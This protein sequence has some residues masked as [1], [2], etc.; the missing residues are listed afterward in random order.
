VDNCI[1]PRLIISDTDSSDDW[2]KSQ[3]RHWNHR[4]QIA[5]GHAV[6]SKRYNEVPA[7]P[8]QNTYQ[9]YPANDFDIAFNE[10]PAILDLNSGPRMWLRTWL[11]TNPYR[12]PNRGE[13][14]SLETLS[15]LPK[16]EI[17]SWLGQHISL[18]PYPEAEPIVTIPEETLCQK[19]TPRYRSKCRRSQRR[20][21][22]IPET[23]GENRVLECTH[24]CGQSFDV[25]GQWA[26]HERRNIEEWKCHI[27]K[28]ISPRK[29][30]LR[31]HLRQYHGFRGAVKKS[32]CRQLLQPN[33]RPCGFCLKQFDNWSEWLNHVGAHFQSR[34]PGGP[35][36]MA[37]WNEAVDVNLDLG[38]SDDDDDDDNDDNDD[39]DNDQGY[40]EPDESSP[41]DDNSTT[42][43]NSDS[44]TKRKEAS[45]G[46]GSKKSSRSSGSS[47]SGAAGSRKSKSHKRASGEPLYREHS[48]S[49]NDGDGD[50][51]SKSSDK[52]DKYRA[53]GLPAKKER[54]RHARDKYSTKSRHYHGTHP[55]SKTKPGSDCNRHLEQQHGR[56][57]DKGKGNDET[58]MTSGQTP[59]TPAKQH[60]PSPQRPVS[61]NW[62]LNGVIRDTEMTIIDSRWTRILYF[63]GNGARELS[64]S[65]ILE[66]VMLRFNQLASCDATC[67]DRF[68]LLVG[69]STGDLLA[70]M[71]SKLSCVETHPSQSL[72]LRPSPESNATFMLSQ[73]KHLTSLADT[74]RHI[75]NSPP[76][77]LDPDLV[78]RLDHRAES[79]D[80]SPAPKPELSSWHRDWKPQNIPIQRRA[81]K[82]PSCKLP[83]TKAHAVPTYQT[84]SVTFHD[85]T[86]GARLF[87]LKKFGNIYSRIMNPMVDVFERR[88][89]ALGGHISS[90]HAKPKPEGSTTATVPQAKLPTREK[91]WE[92]HRARTR[93]LYLE[94]HKPQDLTRLVDQR[95]SLDTRASAYRSED[96]DSSPC[97]DGDDARSYDTQLI[98]DDEGDTEDV[99]GYIVLRAYSPALDQPTFFFGICD[100]GA[101]VS[102]LSYATARLIAPDSIS[103]DVTHL[104]TRTLGI[105][106]G[107]IT[108]HGPIWVKFWLGDEGNSIRYKA[109]FYVLPP[110]YG[111]GGFDS[112]LSKKVVQRLGLVTIQ[113]PSRHGA[114][115]AERKSRR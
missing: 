109:P 20:F 18:G 37:R 47:R 5:Q 108:V 73:L 43:K 39:N 14:E 40:D 80:L 93:K 50:C 61:A 49:S 17:M 22:Y 59:Q 56:Q 30:K 58:T 65:T 66:D 21:R 27:C 41:E 38:D 68:S 70:I 79:M 106:G 74:I 64:S 107:T 78:P 111:E 84:T 34:I 92:K 77:G 112:L 25:T 102:V 15:G 90:L 95:A 85:S 36:T 52:G 87:G 99:H 12:M 8:L 45:Y 63:D 62:G 97:S 33:M 26:R 53:K 98:S 4:E 48:C 1:D 16:T 9:H 110:G 69:T 100:T 96:G 55:P 88:I 51:S 75:H 44:S 105:L 89:A 94:A 72:R 2:N 76:S 57:Y 54:N 28:F 91:D 114:R 7:T 42:D 83:A 11:T 6:V 67:L 29:Y 115:D 103:N 24:G 60:S 46:S 13:L 10:N 3:N 104:N 86:H 19:R 35:W 113:R 101:D 81:S 31:S 32:H 23:R 71:L 82:I